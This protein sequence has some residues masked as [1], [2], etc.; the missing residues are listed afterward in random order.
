MLVRGS[1]PH[2]SFNYPLAYK[3]DLLNNTGCYQC[4]NRYLTN[5]PCVK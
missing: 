5:V 3:A 2:R 1:N 4:F